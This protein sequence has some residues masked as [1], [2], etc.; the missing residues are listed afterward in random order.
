MT[1]A[2]RLSIIVAL[3]SYLILVAVFFGF[4]FVQEAALTVYTFE[5][6]A[7]SSLSLLIGHHLF[8]CIF[9]VYKQVW[10]YTGVRELFF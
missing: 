2:Q 3:D 5:M 7:I 4:Q 8:A 10:A 1:Y 9:H 6:L